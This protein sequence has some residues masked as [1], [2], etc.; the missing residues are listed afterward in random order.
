MPK[1]NLSYPV[2][3]S[4]DQVDKCNPSQRHFWIAKVNPKDLNHYIRFMSIPGDHMAIYPLNVT[5]HLP[6]GHYVL[7]CGYGRNKLRRHFEVDLMGVRFLEHVK[8]EMVY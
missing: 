4:R 5:V 6:T 3:L 2:S 8:S 7:G 1:V